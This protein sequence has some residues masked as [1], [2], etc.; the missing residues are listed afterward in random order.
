MSRPSTAKTATPAAQ[1]SEVREL[2]P[3]RQLSA[4]EEARVVAMLKECHTVVWR[5]AYRMGLNTAQADDAT[6]QAF[7]AASRRIADIQ[8]GRE[9][10][11]LLGSVVRA[12]KNQQRLAAH[13]YEMS[14]TLELEEAP[15]GALSPHQLVELKQARVLL[16]RVLDGLP[17]ATREAFVLFELEGLPLKEIRD[18]LEIPMGTLASRLRRAREKFQKEVDALR[19]SG[20]AR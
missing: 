9:R 16:D 6:Q 7:I 12:A 10:S 20:G 11:F 1:E 17:E 13:R 19:R 5:T 15:D 2:E 3:A 8:P 18:L 4:A 14:D